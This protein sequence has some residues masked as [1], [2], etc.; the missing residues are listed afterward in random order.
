[1]DTL[2]PLIIIIYIA[3]FSEVFS[4]KNFIYFRGFILAQMLLG[5]TRKCVTNIA[6]VCFFV[7]RDISTW[8]RFL[9]QHHWDI[10]EIRKI[11]VNLIKEELGEKMKVYG[12]YLA[13]ID[14]TLVAK[15][16]GKM[17]GIQKWPVHS[18]NPDKGDYLIGHHWAIASLIGRSFI[19]EKLIPLCFPILAGLISG[20]KNPIGSAVTSDGVVSQMDFWYTT[21][22]LVVQIKKMLGDAPLRVVADAYFSKA[23]FINWMLDYFIDVVTR[24]RVDGVGWDDPLPKVPSGKKKR[25]RP[26]TKP[27]KGKKWKIS[28][29]LKEFPLQEVE[30]SVYGKLKTLQIV[31]RELWI[32]GVERQKVKVVVIKTSSDPVILISTDLKLAPKEIIH[33][34]SLR[35]SLETTIRELKQ[36][37]GFGDY[38]AVRT[39]SIY[40]FTGL[41]IVSLSL[42][43]MA[44][45]FSIYSNWL[46]LVRDT[47]TILSF[48]RMS[49]A[50][51]KNILIRIFENS[52][53]TANFQNSTITTEKIIRLMV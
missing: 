10:N 18:N 2:F 4:A 16:M 37:F 39:C 38:Q 15:V 46:N 26:R 48:K 12:S 33:I 19:G 36:S 32:R 28:Q 14:T 30:V 17:M 45:L 23:S 9:S 1:M 34:Y 42:W 24:M 7:E 3:H 6:R 13:C 47:F 44:A 25:G 50:V 40:R 27:E 31:T 21:C 8:E 49:Q 35:F 41:S 11:L 20:K 22:P 43:R 52:A 29:L 5:E 51:R 53:C